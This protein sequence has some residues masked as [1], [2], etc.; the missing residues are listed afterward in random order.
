[1]NETVRQPVYLFGGFRLDA[2]RRVL[3]G[4]DGETI[5][6][7]P[8]LFDALLYFVERAGQLQTK[9]ELLEALWSNVV[10]EEHNLNKTVSELRRVLGEQPGEHRFIVTK[11]GRGY[12]FVADVSIEPLST[13]DSRSVGRPSTPQI[14]AGNEREWRSRYGRFA[15]GALIVTAALAT[16][17]LLLRAPSS[18]PAIAASTPGAEGMRLSTIT[19]TPLTFD[20]GPKGYPQLS[21]DAQKIAFAW[22]GE[23]PGNQDIYIKVIGSDTRSLRVTNH[24]AAENFPVWSPNG[25]RLAFIRIEDGRTSIHT[26]PWTGGESTKIVD[27]VGRPFHL[28]YPITTPS[29]SPD[30]RYLLYGERPPDAPARVVR[31]DLNTREKRELTV[32][33]TRTDAVGDFAP[34]VSPDGRNVAFVRGSGSFINLDIWVMDLDGRNVRRLTDLRMYEVDGIAWTPDGR[35]LLF[36][37][38]DRFKH[39]AY[40]IDL[41]TGI[42][43]P[44]AGL[45]ENDRWPSVARERLVFARMNWPELR[46]WQ[47]APRSATERSGR[48]F[49]IDG[50][51]LTFS[52][53]DGRMAWHSRQSG[54]VQIWIA[55]PAGTNAHMLTAMTDAWDPQ[56]SPDGR[57][58][59]FWSYEHE[60]QSDIYFVDPDTRHVLR[61]TTHTAD[62]MN[63]TFSSDG[64]WVYFCS[65]RDGTPQIYRM[66]VE[67]AEHAEPVTRE[68][69][70]FAS[71][72]RDGRY[73]YYEQ[74]DPGLGFPIRTPVWRLELGSD[75]PP[76]EVL[77]GWPRAERSWVLAD[78][79]IYQLVPGGGLA[80]PDLVLRYLDFETG[81][82]SELYRGAGEV[83]HYPSVSP[84][85]RLVL[86]TKHVAPPKSDLWMLEGLR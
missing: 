50:V 73:L 23:Q 28:N 66:P 40:S 86:F 77:P 12:R 41:G 47:A 21:P 84:D 26:V 74:F 55:D 63:P 45:G 58:I 9:E 61:R 27:V 44:L 52:P 25:D 76:D 14:P 24:A 16:T 49:G 3:Y 5:A 35:E 53:A 20:G 64:R 8:R 4:V 65:T 10:V 70:C 80:G 43:R 56:W 32:P 33:S 1:V 29:W 59:A 62:D 19:P 85:E 54:S 15:L 31:L 18:G 78:G 37:A 34:S 22:N 36:T 72:S 51:K 2:Q 46:L 75:A 38:G 13:T 82:S 6:L 79:G 83:G 17:A 68:G 71:A 39:S 7:T 11:P 30:G 42:A 69:G 48:D 57:L 60:G 81:R 67:G